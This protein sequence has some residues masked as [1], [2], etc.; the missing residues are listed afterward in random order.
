[1]SKSARSLFVFG[2]YLFQGCSIYTGV[3][4]EY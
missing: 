3:K 2:L 4:D 1:M